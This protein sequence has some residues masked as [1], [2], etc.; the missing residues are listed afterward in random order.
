ME[1]SH[2]QPATGK[3]E[4]TTL[5]RDRHAFA[6]ERNDPLSLTEDGMSPQQ[7]EGATLEKTMAGV[8]LSTVVLI[9]PHSREGVGPLDREALWHGGE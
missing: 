1:I 8:V 7:K 9:E 4:G 5:A 3:G 6:T 2:N